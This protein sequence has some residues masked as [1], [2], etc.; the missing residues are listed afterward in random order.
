MGTSSECGACLN[1]FYGMSLALQSSSGEGFLVCQQCIDE[2]MH[3]NAMH[4]GDADCLQHPL[5]ND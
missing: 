2:Q 3:L 4:E 1:E 5:G